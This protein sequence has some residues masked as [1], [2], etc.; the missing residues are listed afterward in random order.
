MDTEEVVGEFKKMLAVLEVEHQIDY[1]K[2]PIMDLIRQ[3]DHFQKVYRE[4]KEF[5]IQMDEDLTQLKLNLNRD[6]LTI[7]GN[8]Y[9]IPVLIHINCRSV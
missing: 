9:K 8:N 6:S 4:N 1:N 3:F 5:N 7:C 2:I